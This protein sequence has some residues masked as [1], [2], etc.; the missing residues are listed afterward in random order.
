MA[1]KGTSEDECPNPSSPNVSDYVIIER[2]AS[3][4]L[5]L[6]E[7]SEQKYIT[8]ARGGNLISWVRQHDMVCLQ[9]YIDAKY[10]LRH[11]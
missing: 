9:S 5:P 1:G 4:T 2:Q 7:P 6:I 10:N 8:A 3:K 11:E